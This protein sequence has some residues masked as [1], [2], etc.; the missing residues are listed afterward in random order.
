MNIFPVDSLRPATGGSPRFEG[1]E[2]GFDASFFYVTAPKGKGAA[3]HRHPYPEVFLVIEGEIQVG[4]EG[5]STE[6]S[7]G[8]MTVVPAN[9]WHEFKV[10]SAIPVRM[11]NIHPAGTMVQEFAAGDD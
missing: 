8:N 5:E 6:L 2:F 1:A 4:V 7:A 9:T 3:R 11:V 10:I